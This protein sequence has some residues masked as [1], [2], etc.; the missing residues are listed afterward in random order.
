MKIPVRRSL[1][2]ARKVV[3]ELEKILPKEIAKNCQVESWANGREQGL[4]LK[5]W[6]AEAG[7]LFSKMAVFS[8]A[9][10]SDNI[11]VIAGTSDDFCHQTNQPNE[12]AY[13]NRKYF[14][15]NDYSGAAKYVKEF[16][17]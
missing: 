3:K 2:V 7:I 13:E 9:R 16:L 14:D 5:H 1:I 4:C 10:S 15:C 12:Q 6:P 11:L 8:E 17:K